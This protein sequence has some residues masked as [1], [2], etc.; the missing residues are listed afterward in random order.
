MDDSSDTGIVLRAL[1][2]A[3]MVAKP[4]ILNSDQGS[5]FTSRACIDFV[6]SWISLGRIC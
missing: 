6:S 1:N 4:K 3:F 2:K 5:Q